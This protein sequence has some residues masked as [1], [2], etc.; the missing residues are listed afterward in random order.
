VSDDERLRAYLH[1]TL[2]ADGDVRS[3]VDGWDREKARQIVDLVMG[4]YVTE[5]NRALAAG[6][7]R[8]YGQEAPTF[9]RQY[10][11]L[12]RLKLSL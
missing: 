8:L 2:V 12:W 10:G 6:R 9:M 11:E 7:D 3:L 4:D 1:D 5:L